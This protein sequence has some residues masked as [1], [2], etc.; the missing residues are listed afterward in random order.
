MGVVLF[1]FFLCATMELS[2][3][4]PGRYSP[5]S[6]EIPGARMVVDLL[7]VQPLIRVFRG[8]AGTIILPIPCFLEL[9]GS[10]ISGMLW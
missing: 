7:V 8:Q 10:V 1:F 3:D 4:I 5:F 6:A 2:L 9:R